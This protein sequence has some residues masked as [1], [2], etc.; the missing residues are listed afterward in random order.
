ML[1]EIAQLLRGSCVVYRH[2]LNFHEVCA[3]T[4]HGILECEIYSDSFLFHLLIV[5]TRTFQIIVSE[6]KQMRPTCVH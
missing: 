6:A 5:C 3:H 4:E 2:L 1:T